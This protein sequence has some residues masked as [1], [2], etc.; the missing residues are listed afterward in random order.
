MGTRASK[1]RPSQISVDKTLP[2]TRSGQIGVDET[3]PPFVPPTSWG[4]HRMDVSRPCK[5]LADPITWANVTKMDPLIAAGFHNLTCSPLCRLPEELLLDIMERLDM[6]SIQCLRRV[7]RLFLRLFC[8]PVFNH[9]QFRKREPYTYKHWYEAKQNAGYLKTLAG[10]LDKDVSG[11]CGHCRKMRIEGGKSKLTTDFLHCSRCRWDHPRCL[12]SKAQREELAE[13]R[14]CI[15]WEGF[16]R[17]CDHQ[18]LT[19]DTA[20]QTGLQL[21]TVHTEGDAFAKVLLV[22]CKHESHLPQHHTTV[23]S[24]TRHQIRYPELAIFKGRKTGT[25]FVSL[26]WHGHLLLQ[27][28]LDE[29]GNNEVATPERLRQQLGQFREGVAEF[30]APEFPPGRLMEM[31]CFDP[32]RCSCLRYAGMEQLPRGWQLTHRLDGGFM[33]CRKDPDNRLGPL[34]A[35]LDDKQ[36]STKGRCHYVGNL[37]TGVADWG[38]SRIMLDIEPCPA[39]SRCLQILYTRWTGITT[40]DHKSR[41]SWA[42]CQMLDPHS[43][44]LLDDAESFG[45]LWCQQKGCRNYYRY[46]RKAPFPLIDTSR[47]CTESCP[48]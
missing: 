40:A 37:T 5:C 21:A 31:N 13:K 39:E 3:L 9:N 34:L 18:V 45:I 30:I 10:L 29:Q 48:R 44:N 11:Y 33:A 19:W 46:V 41:I 22:R 6:P 15:G 35:V 32:N 47:K 7:S 36:K 26:E 2:S 4:G 14:V 23:P 8:S 38:Y 12:F 25:I 28:G 1:L 20:I 42:W 27:T 17:L 24:L 43:Y 16:I